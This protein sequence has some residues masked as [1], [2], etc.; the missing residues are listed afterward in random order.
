MECHVFLLGVSILSLCAIF[1]LDFERHYLVFHFI[2]LFLNCILLNNC[3]MKRDVLY[4]IKR[5]KN[6]CFRIV[7]SSSIYTPHSVYK[8]FN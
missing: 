3:I 4:G 5:V 2:L 7:G 1:L 6:M 8:V